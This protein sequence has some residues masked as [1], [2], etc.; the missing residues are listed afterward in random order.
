M[1]IGDEYPAD[2][3]VNTSRAERELVIDAFAAE[4]LLPIESVLNGYS[5]NEDSLRDPS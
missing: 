1:I 3:G 2:L 4:L 5:G